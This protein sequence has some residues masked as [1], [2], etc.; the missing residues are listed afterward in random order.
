MNGDE[1]PFLSGS[2][3]IPGVPVPGVVRRGKMGSFE[4]VFK[5]GSFLEE[6]LAREKVNDLQISVISYI[7]LVKIY[8]KHRQRKG[9][10]AV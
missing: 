9:P 8:R 1:D 4:P 3:D 7:S 2:G 6:R 5:G 10:L